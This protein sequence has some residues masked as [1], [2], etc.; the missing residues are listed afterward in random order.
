M[1]TVTPPLGRHD[2][3]SRKDAEARLL[4]FGPNSLPAAPPENIFRIFMRQFLSPL[5]Y[6]L[7][8]AAIVSLALADVKDAFFIGVVLILN[9][10]IGTIQEYSAG[11]AAAAL[12]RLQ[13][14]FST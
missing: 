10:M 3:L 11:R 2:G 14:P 8:A 13:E 9:G 1:S 12:N 4:R 5:I 7:L 6:I